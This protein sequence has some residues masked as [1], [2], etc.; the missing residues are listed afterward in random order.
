L[1]TLGMLGRG[2]VR[3][4]WR[5]QDFFTGRFQP[6]IVVCLVLDMVS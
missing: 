2:F 3:L 4:L 5:T 1:Q 6:G